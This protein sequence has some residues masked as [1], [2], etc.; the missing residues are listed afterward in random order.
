MV[1]HLFSTGSAWNY[2]QILQCTGGKGKPGLGR[3]FRQVGLAPASK[4]TVLSDHLVDKAGLV[5]AK[6]TEQP[7]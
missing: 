2:K 7:E 5:S 3:R 4:R 6:L 1:V